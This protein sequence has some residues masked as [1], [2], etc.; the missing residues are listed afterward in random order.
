MIMYVV[1]DTTGTYRC[2]HKPFVENHD[3]LALGHQPN[4]VLLVFCCSFVSLELY[5]D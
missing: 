5:P 3:Q 2:I 1:R 4:L